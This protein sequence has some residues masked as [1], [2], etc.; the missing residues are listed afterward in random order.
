ME[1]YIR[2]QTT[3]IFAGGFWSKTQDAPCG[4]AGCAQ[5]ARSRFPVS[6]AEEA[7]G[8]LNGAAFHQI[9]MNGGD[10]SHTLWPRRML[11]SSSAVLCIVYDAS[12]LVAG[13]DGVTP[14]LG[15]YRCVVALFRHHPQLWPCKFMCVTQS[16]GQVLLHCG[17]LWMR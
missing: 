15:V 6:R 16:V 9:V 13:E 2:P 11:Y 5:T 17:E 10:S 3:T 1:T 7:R 4:Y 8:G 12:E 14:L